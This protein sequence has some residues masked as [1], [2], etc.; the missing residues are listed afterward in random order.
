MANDERTIAAARAQWEQKRV[1]P[2]LKRGP[3]RRELFTTSSGID[4]KREYDPGDLDGFNFLDDLGFPGDY[5]FTRGVQP[6]MY[7][8]RLWTM[9]QYAG[10]GDAEESNRRYRYL[11]ANGQ[12]GL[13]VAFDLPTQMGRDP[14]HQLA[15]GEVGRVGVSISSL[16]DMET[17]LAELPLDRIST[18]MTINATASILLA[19]YLV[20]AQKRDVGWD[21]LNGTIQ[22][23]IL[24]EYVARGTYIYPPR[25]SMRIITD[26]FDFASREV[27]NWNTISISGYHIREAGSTAVQEL[28]FTLADGIAYVEAALKAGLKIDEFANRLSFFFNVHNNFFEEIAKFRAARRLWARI[29]KERFKAADERSMMMRFHAQTAG[30]TLTAQQVDNNV[31]RVTLQ[32]LAAVLG[33]AQSL[34]TNSKDEAQALPSETSALLAL[35]TQ[36]LIAY[37]SDVTDTAD[38]LGGSY[39]LETLTNELEQRTWEYLNKI[40]DMGG[41]VAAIERGFM[42]R[43]IHNAAFAYQREIES[44]ERI[45]VG[46]NSFTA[47]YEAPADILKVNPAIEEKQRSRVA[48][49]RAE[50]DQK[51]A[52]NS[53]IHVEQAARDGSNLMPPIIDAVRA[54]A[55]L[56]EI[57]DAMRQ[58]FGEYQPVNEL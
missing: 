39:Y 42:Q 7:R 18:S 13:S 51:A 44:K 1:A 47:G 9:R 5:P 29:M 48:R 50:R 32:A 31:V 43:E 21:K 56:G 22:N 16:E 4:V 6:T 25:G 41:A 14:D 53:L 11:F 19:L 35:R 27:P 12:T 52:Q 28:A 55:T 46:V 8:G 49:V 20:V 33:G 3:E 54:W 17:L 36:Q 37:E 15:R 40:D 23:D 26:I 30:S 38:P 10:F 58:V 34:H 2:A 57:A 45:I 24:K